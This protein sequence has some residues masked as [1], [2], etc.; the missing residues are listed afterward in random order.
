MCD[1]PAI[2]ILGLSLAGWNAVVS[3][4][5]TALAARAAYGSSTESQ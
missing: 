3:L 1:Q 5:I 4:G 2:Q